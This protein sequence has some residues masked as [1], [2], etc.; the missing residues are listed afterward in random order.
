MARSVEENT[1]IRL[2]DS[3]SKLIK[4]SVKA[5]DMGK[6]AEHYQMK[7]ASVL[8]IQKAYKIY[9]A[10]YKHCNSE[11]FAQMIYV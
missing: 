10:E 9:N 1:S 7:T 3:L 4:P 11:I 8:N 5:R 6:V 2:V